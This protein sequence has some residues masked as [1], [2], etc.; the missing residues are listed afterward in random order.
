MEN[1]QQNARSSARS[2]RRK[3]RKATAQSLRNAALFYLQR[4]ATSAENLRRVLKRRVERAA[5]EYGSDVQE[6][7]G[8]VNEI[9]IRYRETGL[10]DDLV[11]AKA[12]TQSLRRRGNS[13]RMIFARLQAKGVAREDIELAL[14]ELDLSVTDADL[15]AAIIIARRRRFG[16]WRLSDRADR[17]MRDLAA[18]AR[19]G[20]SYAVSKQVIDA[21]SAAHLE[22]LLSVQS[23]T[24]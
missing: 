20:F 5:L 9:I 6:G 10:L 24:K 4:Y 12:Q 16:P 2:E 11:Y 15:S 17:R 3:P 21:E 23:S 22:E 7:A 19:R 14:T 1:K 8:F 13:L 18:L